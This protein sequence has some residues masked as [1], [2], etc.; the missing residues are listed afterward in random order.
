MMWAMMTQESRNSVTE[1][2]WMK[3]AE[4]LMKVAR[5]S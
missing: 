5:K 2:A 1:L 3:A 4:A